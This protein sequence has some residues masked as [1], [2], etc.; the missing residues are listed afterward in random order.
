[1]MGQGKPSSKKNSWD[2]QKGGRSG[3]TEKKKHIGK[4]RGVGY[5]FTAGCRVEGKKG[6]KGEVHRNH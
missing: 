5:H 3:G 4:H 6:G 1:M 2:E